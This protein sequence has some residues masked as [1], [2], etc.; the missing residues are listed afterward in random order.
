MRHF[1]KRKNFLQ[2]N[3]LFM[4]KCCY[5]FLKDDTVLKPLPTAASSL[6]ARRIK[7]VIQNFQKVAEA[8]NIEDHERL[9]LITYGFPEERDL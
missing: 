2:K 7:T 9:F 3:L 4:Y 6:T 1:D 5:V 8:S